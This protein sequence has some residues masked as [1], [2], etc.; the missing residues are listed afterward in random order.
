MP[1]ILNKNVTQAKSHANAYFLY[2]LA[3]FFFALL[4]ESS[5]A[6][7]KLNVPVVLN[8]FLNWMTLI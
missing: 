3:F 2:H 7:I 6:T 1:N 8:K 4:A 5:S